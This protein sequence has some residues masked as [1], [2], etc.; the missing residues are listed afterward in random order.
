[1]HYAKKTF[2]YTLDDVLVMSCAVQRINGGYV[3]NQSYDYHTEKTTFA[4]KDLVRNALATANTTPMITTLP[5]DEELA[6]QVKGWMRNLM[7]Q[8]IGGNE[9]GYIQNLFQFSQLAEVENMYQLATLASAPSAFLRNQERRKED[10]MLF[11]KDNVL[12]NQ[13]GEKVELE[14]TPVRCNFS[15]NWEVFFVTAIVDD[16]TVF[17]SQKN[18]IETGTPIRIKATVKDHKENRT[19]L[20]RVKII[21]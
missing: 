10:K 11:G 15:K 16:S 6:N 12:P 7:L 4:N 14:V 2:S 21:G 5:E 9:S 13:I 18:A 19:Q 8:V 3:K 20:N 17:F 1:M